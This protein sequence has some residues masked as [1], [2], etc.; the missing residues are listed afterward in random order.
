MRHSRIFFFVTLFSMFG[1]LAFVG[2]SCKT[3]KGTPV[4]TGTNEKRTLREQAIIDDLSDSFDRYSQMLGLKGMKKGVKGKQIRIWM[5]YALSDSGKLIVL[6]RIRNARSAQIFYYKYELDQSYNVASITSRKEENQ[7]MSGWDAF[8]KR[9]APFWE[10][11]LK[12][13][14]EIKN[15]FLCHGGDALFVE[16]AE[17]KKYKAFEFPCFWVDED[18]VPEVIAIGDALMVI[19][20]EFNYR[21]F[22]RPEIPKM[23]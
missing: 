3:A 10:P 14:W 13:Y 2:G 16:I 11:N 9:F 17:R 21:L 6:N 5:N 19:Q 22:P 4:T 8:F 15:Y 1:A 7:P 18:A 12:N 20:T 23:K